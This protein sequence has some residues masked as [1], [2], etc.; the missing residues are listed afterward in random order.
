MCKNTE[1]KSNAF[2][3]AYLLGVEEKVLIRDYADDYKAS[4]EFE[5]IKKIDNAEYVRMLSRVRQSLLRNFSKYKGVSSFEEASKGYLDEELSYL[6]DKGCNLNEVFK[7]NRDIIDVI[8]ATTENINKVIDQ[9]LED[10]KVI[11]RENIANLF[12]MY[13]F[14]KKNI[15]QFLRVMKTLPIPHGIMICKYMRIEGS[16]PYL[17][18]N[19]KNLI[20]SCNTIQGKCLKG[21]IV[22]PPYAWG[23]DNE[24]C[25]CE[26]KSKEI[27]SYD[28]SGLERKAQE[29]E[30]IFF[31]G[32]TGD[33]VGDKLFI[34]CDNID[35]FRFLSF[36]RALDSSSV[37]VF[38]LYIDS[39]ASFLWRTLDKIIES[40]HIFEYV[41][42][43]RIKG[44]KS[45][46]DMVLAVD[47]CKDILMN[48]TTRIGII[49]SDSDYYGLIERFPE[50]QFFV[51]YS[52]SYTNNDYLMSI[53]E[54]GHRTLNLDLFD[55][56]E[57]TYSIT[58]KCIIYLCLHTLTLVPI[59]K[60]ELE[61]LIGS[62]YGAIQKETNFDISMEY[63]R[64]KV[65]EIRQNL[66]IKIEGDKIHFSFK[67]INLTLNLS[68]A[69]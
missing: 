38:R 18:T 1:A 51:G 21:N 55:S 57:D 8:N 65:L 26:T 68:S 5:S 39:K 3:V 9:V 42:V 25:D 12:Y 63:V 14:N 17:L 53:R 30:L 16:L 56:E 49:S 27:S 43:Q 28:C 23:T 36:V 33:I 67:D 19:D 4:K 20:V 22:I 2:I 66:N 62:V 24:S 69:I 13:E 54:K 29:Q 31:E 6:I 48:N 46:V 64:E 50:V 47:I 58:D 61:D 7:V 44:N 11:E 45:I 59:F 37:K 10:L 40:K 32:T 34:D 35:F 52:Y 41:D 15:M 60:W